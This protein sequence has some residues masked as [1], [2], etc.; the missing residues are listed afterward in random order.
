MAWVWASESSWWKERANFQK[1]SSVTF[2]LWL[3]CPA[4]LTCKAK[5][6]EVTYILLPSWIHVLIL[7]KKIRLNLR[8]IGKWSLD[9]SWY[10]FGPIYLI[11]KEPCIFPPASTHHGSSV[12][13]AIDPRPREPHFKKQSL[14]LVCV[15]MFICVPKHTCGGWRSAWER[16]SISV[17][18]ESWGLNAG[19]QAKNQVPFPTEPSLWPRSPYLMQPMEM[20]FSRRHSRRVAEGSF[21]QVEV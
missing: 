5:R 8:A 18:C 13:L 12:S 10:R 9:F 11:Q 21:W 17:L 1:L 3:T 16:K 15:P 6:K 14:Q 20:C 7:K 19:G 4:P 2:T